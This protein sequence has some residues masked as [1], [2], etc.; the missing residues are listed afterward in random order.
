MEEIYTEKSINELDPFEFMELK[1][2][3]RILPT[4][5]IIKVELNTENIMELFKKKFLKKV[6]NNKK[7]NEGFK[8]ILKS[9][10]EEYEYEI[11]EELK[12]ICTFKL[13]QLEGKIILEEIVKK[14]NS[15]IEKISFQTFIDKTIK[16]VFGYNTEEEISDLLVDSWLR[17]EEL[18]VVNVLDELDI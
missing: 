17:E 3:K 2:I 16:E 6:K 4:Q 5:N 14:P 15:K 10:L 9:N 8:T 7:Y 12:L 13:Q 11:I 1:W 18:S